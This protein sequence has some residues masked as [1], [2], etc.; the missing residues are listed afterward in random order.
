MSPPDFSPASMPEPSAP[1]RAINRV[2]EASHRLNEAVQKAVQ[3]GYSV[4]LARVS[5]FHDGAGNWG[6]QIVPMVK[7]GVKPPRG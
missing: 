4:E 5:R 1:E 3:S 7:E 2:A 6:D